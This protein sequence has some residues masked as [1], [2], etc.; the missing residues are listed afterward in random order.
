MSTSF[1]FKPIVTD[2]LVFTIDAANSKSFVSGSTSWYDLSGGGNTGT[3][4]NGPAYDSNNGGSLVFDGTDDFVNF[5][6]TT[7]N[8]YPNTSDFT[9]NMWLKFGAFTG[10]YRMVWY[11]NAGGGFNG[12]GIVLQDNANNFIFE[13]RGSNVTRQRISFSV[14]SYLNT[15]NYWSF[16][17]VQSTLQVLVYV[18]GSLLTTLSY[19]DWGGAINKQGSQNFMLGSH[20]GTIWFY[21]GSIGQ[22]SAYKGKALSATEILQNYNALKGR[23][24]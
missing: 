7:P 13:I 14:A 15:W 9:I 8:L 17:I 4:T 12:V 20:A 6:L 22:V 16:A 5:G 21:N 1:A 11:G 19:S 18:N 10:T 3:L 2:G 24:I 23:Y